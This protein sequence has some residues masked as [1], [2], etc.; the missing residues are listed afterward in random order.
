MLKIN[1]R[2]SVKPQHLLAHLFYVNI[3]DLDNSLSPSAS[4]VASVVPTIARRKPIMRPLRQL[5]SPVRLYA[6]SVHP[7][8]Q[9]GCQWP[10]LDGSKG[11]TFLPLFSWGRL[12][13]KGWQGKGMTFSIFTTARCAHKDFFPPFVCEILKA[14]INA[15][16]HSVL[17]AS[18]IS[19]GFSVR[20]SFP[21]LSLFNIF[22][23][24]CVD[25]KWE[26]DWGCVKI[27]KS[28][29]STW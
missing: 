20:L 15:R 11:L 12:D 14:Q 8:L 29:S 5:Y 9:Q 19:V 13:L 23:C 2:R 22:R 10:P 27:R 26:I 3:H 18:G 21:S 24:G 1:V 17:P 7:I 16:A 6:N 25:E 4:V 28:K